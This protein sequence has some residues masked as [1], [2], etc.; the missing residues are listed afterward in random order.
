MTGHAAYLP[1]RY[2]QFFARAE[3][4]RLWDVD[5]REFIDFMY[6]WGPNLPP[7]GSVRCGE[8]PQRAQAALGG[9]PKALVARIAHADWVMS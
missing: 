9:W 6:S 2:P 3:G 7:R 4:C 8:K 5:G 1:P